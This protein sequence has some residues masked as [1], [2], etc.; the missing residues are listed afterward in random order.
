MPK[1]KRTIFYAWQSDID[2]RFNRYLIAGAL[3][4]AIEE[5]NSDISNPYELVLDHDTLNEPGAPKIT[6]TILKKIDEAAVFVGDISVTGKVKLKK[7]VSNPN[8]MLELGYALKSLSEKRVILLANTAHAPIEKL[9]FDTKINRILPYNVSQKDFDA[10]DS[11]QLLRKKTKQLQSDLKNAIN[12]ILRSPVTANISEA[13]RRL[14]GIAYLAKNISHSFGPEGRQ[15]SLDK[16]T[17][18]NGL[19]IAENLPHTDHI[20]QEAMF[21]L[22]RLAEEMRYHVGDGAKTSIIICEKMIEGFYQLK[23]QGTALP[24]IL[25]I[26]EDIVQSVVEYIRA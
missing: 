20:S 17:T 18:R 15:F 2:G 26:S 22:S 24:E 14:G 8:V 10:E 12:L 13:E 7:Y 9:P 1:E 3:K 23:K 11:A 6:E 4:A 16:T 5:L 19:K 21:H 25:E